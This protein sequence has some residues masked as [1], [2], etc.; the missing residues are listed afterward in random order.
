MRLFIMD[1]PPSRIDSHTFCAGRRKSCAFDQLRV[2]TGVVLWPEV[3]D[4]QDGPTV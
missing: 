1:R 3:G 2:R 4:S